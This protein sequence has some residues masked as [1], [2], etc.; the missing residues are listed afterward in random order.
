VETVGQGRVIVVS[1]PSLFI[2]AMVDLP[3]N[4]RFV[5]ALLSGHE[6]VLLDYSHTGDVPPLTAATI[7]VRQ[8]QVLRGF[9]GFLGIGAV[10]LAKRRY[11]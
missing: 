5:R 4:E 2:N 7:A 11:G 1:D 6:T 8:S 9:V 3:G 10:A